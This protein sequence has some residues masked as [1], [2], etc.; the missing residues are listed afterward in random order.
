[1]GNILSVRDLSI[2]IK[3]R[4]LVENVSFDINE[5]EAVL[6]SG[7]NGRGKSTILK[8]ILRLE[9]EGKEI[10]GQ[11]IE[12]SYGDILSLNSTD[13]QKYRASV[14]YVQQKDEYSEMGNIQVRDIISESGEPHSAKSLSYAEVN[15]II[16]KW[17]PR[18]DDG[19][20]VFDAKSKPAKF[21]GGEQRLLSVL[22]VIATRPKAELFIIDE[23]LNNL[24]FV[25]AR[26][27]S[28]LINKV[29]HENPGMGL[30]MISHCRIFPFIT[31]EMKLTKEGITSL[32]KHYECHSCFGEHDENGY[33]TE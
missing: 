29:I 6:L 9:T 16:D 8:S 23:P 3:G 30:I 27:I 15:E 24:D 31:R 17:I 4:P 2:R 22:S 11:I 26:N 25:N 33:Y 18:R 7:A 5:G 20:R 13:L 21:S 1:M 12:R 28:N 10:S 19:S 32:N 14:A